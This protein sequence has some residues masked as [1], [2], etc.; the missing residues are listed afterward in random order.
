VVNLVRRGELGGG[1]ELALRGQHCAALTEG[2]VT[3]STA[4]RVS[5]GEVYA[6]QVGLY[7]RAAVRAAFFLHAY[8]SERGKHHALTIKSNRFKARRSI[9]RWPLFVRILRTYNRPLATKEQQY[10]TKQKTSPYLLH[11]PKDPSLSWGS[12][13]AAI[14]AEY[15]T[16]T[17]T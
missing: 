1:G 14:I 13:N 3:K 9:R 16:N 6:A 11:V 5:F 15:S 4:P 12:T 2:E 17:L 8:F 10:S 7:A